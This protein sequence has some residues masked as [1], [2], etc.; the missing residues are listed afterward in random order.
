MGVRASAQLGLYWPTQQHVPIDGHY[1]I[2]ANAGAGGAVDYGTPLTPPARAW[3]DGEGK[4]GAGL[5]PA[6]YGPA[7][8]GH[9]GAGAGSGPAGLGMAGIGADWLSLRTDEFDDG[10]WILAVAGF[11]A[12]G[13]R[14][15]PGIEQPITVAGSPQEPE[16]N[17]EPQTWTGGV[18]SVD[19]SLS[20]DDEDA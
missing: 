19:F 3:P 14:V 8:Y 5:G 12:A 9:G 17:P 6:G 4:I 1:L 13:N 15:T 2:Y 10:D 18:L 20:P 16:A 7:G 11:D